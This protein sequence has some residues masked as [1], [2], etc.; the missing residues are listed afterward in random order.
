M[1]LTN[2]LNGRDGII[3][4]SNPP[5]HPHSPTFSDHP[6]D[7][8]GSPHS[9][10]SPSASNHSS[11]AYMPRS[12]L[13]AV[14]NGTPLAGAFHHNDALPSVTSAPNIASRGPGRPSCGDPS[15]KAFP[16]T[17]CPKK[18]ARRS[19]LARHGEH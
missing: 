15:M 6:T 19:D 2:I 16:C 13:H 3:P 18:F 11:P 4:K 8:E 7:H 5:S 1:D 17:V 9:S 14:P 12:N 10:T